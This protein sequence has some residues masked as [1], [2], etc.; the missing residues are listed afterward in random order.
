MNYQNILTK[1]EGHVGVITL[2]RPKALN[3][4]N[5]ELLSE[6]I[7]VLEEWD[8]G[9]DVR[10]IVITG[11]DRAFAAGRLGSSASLS[12]SF[13]SRSPWPSCSV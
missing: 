5:S 8:R 2:N 3:A 6:L 13:S 11:S 1:I 7:G 10:C 12:R 4:L 9:I